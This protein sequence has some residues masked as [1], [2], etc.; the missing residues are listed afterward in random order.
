V[1]TSLIVLALLAAPDAPPAAEAAYKRGKQLYKT[2]DKG[3]DLEKF[4]AC[5]Q[6]F[7]KA[8]KIAPLPKY[9]YNA[10]Q[11][12][13]RAGAPAAAAQWYRQYLADDPAASD[14][15]KVEQRI[16]ELEAELKAKE[17]PREAPRPEKKPVD[18]SPA[19]PPAGP[20]AVAPPAAPPAEEARPVYK[21]WWFW[22]AL[23]AVAGGATV[24]IVL[25]TSGTKEV[26]LPGTDLGVFAPSFR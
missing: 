23:V 1:I 12:H 7:E 15:E 25:A 11:C 19:P 26:S 10:A 13:R 9:S 17:S 14:K 6:E 8:Y 21:K 20:A 2:G 5:A 4:V 16:A 18:L 22:T 3:N 24:G